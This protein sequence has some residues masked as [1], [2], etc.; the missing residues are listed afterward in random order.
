MFLEQLLFELN[1]KFPNSTYVFD[2]KASIVESDKTV[3]VSD[4]FCFYM[5]TLV[6][7]YLK[8]PL[9]FAINDEVIKSEIERVR[10]KRI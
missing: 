1:E 2:L 4:G 3:E 8:D 6:K 10:R 7:N 5:N 9:L